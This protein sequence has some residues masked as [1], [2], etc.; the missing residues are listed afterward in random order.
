MSDENWLWKPRLLPRSRY[1]STGYLRS[2]AKDDRPKRRSK[3]CTRASE[4]WSS[5]HRRPTYAVN[6]YIRVEEGAIRA[7]THARELK[8]FFSDEKSQESRLTESLRRLLSDRVVRLEKDDLREIHEFTD[9][10][11]KAQYLVHEAKSH[12]EK[13][14]RDLTDAKRAQAET[15]LDYALKNLDELVGFTQTRRDSLMRPLTTSY[16]VLLNME[17]A[18]HVSAD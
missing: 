5:Y 17:K 11:E 16:R 2:L 4:S 6:R 18:R 8:D 13:A 7:G 12:L 10:F 3:S 9:D 15:E 14:I 1:S